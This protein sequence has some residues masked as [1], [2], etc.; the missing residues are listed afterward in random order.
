MHKGSLGERV[1][2]WRRRLGWS[3]QELANAAKVHRVQI[4][5][6]ERGKA[7]HVE[8]ETVKRLAQVLGVK[9]DYLLGLVGEEEAEADYHMQ[10]VEV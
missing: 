1:H 2:I 9:T 4:S 10:L 8:A 5:K 3:Q 6:I 7:E